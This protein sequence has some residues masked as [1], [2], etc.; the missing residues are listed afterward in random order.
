AIVPIYKKP[1]EKQATLA[2]AQKLAEGLRGLPVEAWF[3]YEPVSVKVD[4]RDHY[5]PGY[6]FAE[7]EL[8]G[9]PIRVELGPKDLEKNAC[10]LARRDRPGKEGKQMGVPLAGAAARIGELLKEMQTA[11]FERARQFRDA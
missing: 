9:A 1:E 6:K 8:K 7:W 10:V 2:A 11:L 3:D 4:D 5:Q